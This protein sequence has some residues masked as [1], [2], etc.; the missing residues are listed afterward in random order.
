M[1]HTQR[2]LTWAWIALV[3]VTL[4]SFVVAESSGIGGNIETAVVIAAAAVKG[5]II[6][7]WFMGA[8]SFP[9]N[10]RLFFAAWLLANV[11]V[12]IGFH[13]IGHG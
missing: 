12:I 4:V 8:P 13:V 1:I 11:A 5:R 9:L 2:A 3:V 7:V 6:L 10:W